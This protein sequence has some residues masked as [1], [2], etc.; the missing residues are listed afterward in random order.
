MNETVSPV[1]YWGLCPQ[2]EP[3]QAPDDMVLNKDFLY[4]MNKSCTMLYQ[5]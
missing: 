1:V 2:S 3:G 5:N 4:K